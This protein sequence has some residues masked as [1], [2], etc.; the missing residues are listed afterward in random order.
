MSKSR[1]RQLFNSEESPPSQATSDWSVGAGAEVARVLSTA[2]AQGEPG[3]PGLTVASA[4][5]ADEQL[6]F[7]RLG[8]YRLLRK[9]GEGGMGVVYEAEHERTRQAVALKLIHPGLAT[10]ASLRR[11]E[12]ELQVMARL[13]HPGIARIYHADTADIG[14]RAQPYFAMELVRGHNLLDYAREHKL[15]VRQR[16]EMA[17]RIADAVQHAHQQSVIHR[18]LKPGNIIVAADGQP[19]ILDFG[20]ARA[21]DGNVPITTLHTKVGQLVGTPAY[22]SPEQAG[23]DPAQIDTRSDV[24]ALG[25]VIY[26]LLTG[27]LPYALNGRMIQ[28]AVRIIREEEPARL[29]HASTGDTN[30]LARE[31]RGDVETIVGK[32]LEKDKDRRYATAN[33]LANDIRRYLNDEPIT[34]R[35]PSAAYQIR[36]FARRNRVLVGGAAATL[37]ALVLAVGGTSYGLVK[38]NQQ[39]ERVEAALEESQITSIDLLRQRGEWDGL[40]ELLRTALDRGYGNPVALRLLR[41]EALDGLNRWDEAVAEAEQLA[42]E[43]NLG[44]LTGSVLLWQGELYLIDQTRYERGISLIREA[45]QDLDPAHPRQEVEIA[46]AEALLADTIP[47]ATEA[48]ERLVASDANHLRGR[49][50]LGILYLLGGRRDESVMEFHTLEAMYPKD[51]NSSL[52][53]AVA[54]AFNNDP[55]GARGAID[56]A[57]QGLDPHSAAQA[58]GVVDVL[59]EVLEFG[60]KQSWDTIAQEDEMTILTKMALPVIQMSMA[61]QGSEEVVRFGRG[62]R[63]RL[64]PAVSLSWGRLVG[65]SVAAVIRG[66]GGPSLEDLRKAAAAN[67]EQVTMGLLAGALCREGLDAESHRLARE[68]LSRPGVYEMRPPLLSLLV[69]VS[70]QRLVLDSS[71]LSSEERE[72]TVNC[73]IELCEDSGPRTDFGTEGLAISASALGEPELARWIVQR[74]IRQAGPSPPMVRLL[75]RI[76]RSH[77]GASDRAAQVEP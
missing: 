62:L 3:G 44:E 18:D 76:T 21:I 17:V 29:S 77:P 25:V 61:S 16:L 30:V 13:D 4:P 15:T 42:A 23:G 8:H 48:L 40:L 75:D 31:L 55:A 9:I 72:F 11:F 7:E 66:R 58:R 2:G 33:G 65:S 27:R 26:E 73:L 60:H 10:Q 74:R 50:M 24:Y 19:K 53:L 32:A 20:V 68:A 1:S 38:A 37:A 34:A 69:A 36:K 63:R 70:T 43:S 64:V 57:A 14:G 46:Y 54:C 47:A 5:R 12:F 67:P 39:R 49:Q 56:R 6:P 52:G 28:E 59:I 51:P 35:P 71:S 22:M 45:L 41:I